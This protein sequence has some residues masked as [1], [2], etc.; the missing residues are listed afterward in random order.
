M[1]QRRKRKTAAGTAMV[2]RS[3]GGEADW[4]PCRGRDT[5]SC[6]GGGGKG[7]RVGN[8]MDSL[9]RGPEQSSGFCPGLYII[10]LP[11]ASRDRGWA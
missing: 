6:R 10:L 7:A 3:P 9:L 11:F 1:E 4:T 5:V 2:R 8:P